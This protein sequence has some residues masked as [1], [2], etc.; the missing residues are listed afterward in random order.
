MAFQD[1]AIDIEGLKTADLTVGN[2][3]DI[4]AVLEAATVHLILPPEAEAA[5]ERL[6]KLMY[7]R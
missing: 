3:R 1:N 6:H 2:V 4:V 7:P 5:L